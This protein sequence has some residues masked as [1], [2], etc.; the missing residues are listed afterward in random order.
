MSEPGTDPRAAAAELELLRRL[1]RAALEALERARPRVDGLNVYPVPDGDTGENLV[2]TVRALTEALDAAEPAP[3]A[4]LQRNLVRALL[5]AARGNS[6]VI[7]SQIVRG[8]VEA[9]P[10]TS[11]LG[12]RALA[13]M[14]EHAR[15]AA[16]AAVSRPVE[17]T[18]LTLMREL[19]AEARA[20][21]RKTL[22]LERRLDALVERGEKALTR[23][24]A[25]N[26][27]LDEAGVVD[28]GAAGLLVCLRAV[29]A[30][31]SGAPSET[32]APALRLVS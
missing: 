3:R 15:D 12:G 21:R 4:L 1:A 17:G 10:A 31:V 11:S 30:A 24:T 8:L 29:V 14:L 25:Q 22:P 7:L 18:M 13:A 6:G 26:P 23:T 27:V 20:L 16:Y 2:H 32:A 19:A 5:M 28:A 9:A